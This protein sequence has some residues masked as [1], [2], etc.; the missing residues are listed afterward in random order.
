MFEIIQLLRMARKPLVA[1]SIAEALGVNVRTIY[2]DVAALQAMRIPIEGE[3]GKGYTFGYG[4][5]LPPL[6]FSG[7]ELEAIAV[8]MSLV[9]KNPDR[10]LQNAATAVLSKVETVLPAKGNSQLNAD[11]DQASH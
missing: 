1:Q 11:N 4:F 3:A 9:Q 5:E 6:L 8:G 7:E 2:R 10:T